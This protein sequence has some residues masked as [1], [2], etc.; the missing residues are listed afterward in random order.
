MTNR[1]AKDAL[2][3]ARDEIDDAINA[4][5]QHHTIAE[6][7]HI[8]KAYEILTPLKVEAEKGPLPLRY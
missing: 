2:F 3:L 5:D 7:E 6:L 8:L 4:I 1:E